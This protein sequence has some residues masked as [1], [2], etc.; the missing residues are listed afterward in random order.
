LI[1]E[2]KVI[3][4]M[5]EKF[6]MTQEQ[7]AQRSDAAARPSQ[8]APSAD[9]PD[10]LK[11]WWPRPAFAGH[12]KVLLGLEIPREIGCCGALR[13]GTNERPHAE[14]VVQRLTRGP[15]TA[16]RAGRYSR[17][18]LRDLSD[19]LPNI[20]TGVGSRLPHAGQRPRRSKLY[21]D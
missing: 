13:G 8:R 12:A 9:L 7:V 5:L 1:E 17:S 15:Q 6:E 16:R 11:A 18:H 14:R 20:R 4:R 3:A 2:A 10:P 19:K 21:H